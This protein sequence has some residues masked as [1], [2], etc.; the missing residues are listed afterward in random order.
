VPTGVRANPTLATLV[1][2]TLSDGCLGETVAAC[3]AREA[4]E[5]TDD[6]EIGALH[7]AIADDEMRH[8]EF[9]F[10]IIA[11]A[12]RQDPVAVVP[13]VDDMIRALQAMPTVGRESDPL[14]R[15]GRW[16]ETTESHWMSRIAHE[17]VIP[18]LRER[19]ASSAPLTVNRYQTLV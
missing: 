17:V 18:S 4:A 5:Q 14:L 6:P 13:V 11:W 15:C 9:A 16:S 3:L 8:A 10:A 1:R 2:E 19:V 12:F 7:A